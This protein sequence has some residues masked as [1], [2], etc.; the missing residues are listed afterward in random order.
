FDLAELFAFGAPATMATPTPKGFLR[1]LRL[2]APEDD[3]D[4]L[5]AATAHLLERFTL[6]GYPDIRE[7][8]EIAT[9]LSRTRWPWAEPVLAALRAGHGAV[10]APAFATGLNAWDRIPEWEEDGPRPPGSHE[11]V[12]PD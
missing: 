8:A 3:A 10:E 12:L 1:A 9:F 4:A 5:L 2:S 7:T 6:P 11:A